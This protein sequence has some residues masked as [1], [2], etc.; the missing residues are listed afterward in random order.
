[1]M[2]SSLFL[3]GE[4]MIRV[5][6]YTIA[7]NNV[8]DVAGWLE[9]TKEADTRAVF[10]LGSTDGTDHALEEAGCIVYRGQMRPPRYDDAL[11][12]AIALMPASDCLFRLDLHERVSAGWLKKIEAT[13][14]PECAIQVLIR[15]D[16][17]EQHYEK[18]IHPSLGF[19]WN[20]AQK[21]TL[22]DRRHSQ[23]VFKI[24]D[25]I[26]QSR[27]IPSNIALL[28]EESSDLNEPSRSFV[29]AEA[30]LQAGILTRGIAQIE[31]F[32]VLKGQPI[33]VAYLWRLAAKIEHTTCHKFL[34]EA[35]TACPCAANYLDFAQYYFRR[36][37]WGQAYN[38][39]Q[40]AFMLMRSGQTPYGPSYTD[41]AKLHNGY[42]HDLAANAAWNLWDFEAAYGHAVEALRQ[43]PESTLLKKQL[44][45]MQAKIA[46]GA[47]IDPSM[48]IIERPAISVQV[49]RHQTPVE[50]VGIVDDLAMALGA[51]G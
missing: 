1:M 41:D 44:Q 18:R 21:P 6:I 38:S 16:L 17:H 22:V 15:F 37:E 42:L 3:G 49:I 40:Y 39:C 26:I 33:E 32:V 20:G 35:Q 11:N 27:P 25:M 8:T 50:P 24:S 2:R 30:L 5:A 29:Y 51:H 28:D 12:T 43:A 48:R 31:R 19:R 34:L 9:T 4:G 45:D 14:L 13:W 36:Q 10:D 7:L 47:T 23:P 46:S